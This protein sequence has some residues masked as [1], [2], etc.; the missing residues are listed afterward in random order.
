M[1]RV[2]DN[3]GQILCEEV[4]VRKRWRDYFAMLL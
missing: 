1:G 3:D 4:E 2:C